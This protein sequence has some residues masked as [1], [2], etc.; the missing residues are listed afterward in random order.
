M[1]PCVGV[2]QNTADDKW[3]ISECVNLGTVFDSGSNYIGGIIASWLK[4]G[5]TIEKSFNFGSL[6]TN[7]NSGGGSGTISG[8]CLYPDA[9]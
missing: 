9:T 4:N 3:V 1:V 8:I 5:G 2:Q 6:S 7:T